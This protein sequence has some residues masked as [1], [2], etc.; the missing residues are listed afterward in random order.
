MAGTL[1]FL[2]HHEGELVRNSLGVLCPVDEAGRFTEGA[3]PFVGRSVLDGERMRVQRTWL[4]GEQT[5]RWALLLDFAVGGQSIVQA[6]TPGGSFEAVASQPAATP[7]T[8]CAPTSGLSFPQA[9]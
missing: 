5:R 4:W 7:L 3:E 2:E 9:K 1:V 6:V 8:T